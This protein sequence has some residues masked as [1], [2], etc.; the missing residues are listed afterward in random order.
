MKNVILYFLIINCGIVKA[1]TWNHYRTP[2]DYVSSIITTDSLLKLIDSNRN[3]PYGYL[4]PE[5]F[6][7]KKNCTDSI[8]HGLFLLL[9]KHELTFEE[10]KSKVDKEFKHSFEFTNFQRILETAI[11]KSKSIY[12]SRG[13]YIYDLSQKTDS[14]TLSKAYYKIYDSVYHA[15]YDSCANLFKKQYAQK[16]KDRVIAISG[17]VVLSAATAQIKE[18]IPLFTSSLKDSIPLYNKEDAELA[19]A[20]LGDSIYQQKYFDLHKQYIKKVLWRSEDLAKDKQAMLFINTQKSIGLLAD[21]LD[22]TKRYSS[23]QEGFGESPNDPTYYFSSLLIADLLKL[24]KDKLSQEEFMKLPENEVSLK[25]TNY[26]M[27]YNISIEQILFMK[28]WM[29]EHKGK[30]PLY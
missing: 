23:W 2:S 7:N 30:Y 9:K 26:I 20:I 25:E 16:I 12:F 29:L 11:D 5:L 1:Q 10:I 15:T 22:T 27:Y 18:A 13:S 17:E 28:R 4:Y 8:K 24:L 6:L 21:W 19:L 14:V 3:Q